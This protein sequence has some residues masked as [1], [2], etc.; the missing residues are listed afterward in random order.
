LRQEVGYWLSR[1][2]VGVRGENA[3][4]EIDYEWVQPS[5]GES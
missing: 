3:G 4:M 2:E 5:F 1:A